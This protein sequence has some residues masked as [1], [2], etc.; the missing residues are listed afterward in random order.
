MIALDSDVYTLYLQGNESIMSKMDQ[1]H[2]VLITLPI[3]VVE[4][5]IRG[6]FNT[7]RQ[8]QTESKRERLPVAYERLAFTI[9]SC[10]NFPLLAYTADAEVLCQKWKKHKIRVPTQ[11][12]RIAA[13]CVSQGFKL[14]TNNTRDFSLIP[15]LA[16][17]TWN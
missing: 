9:K 5:V 1:R 8:C 4:E 2:H 11:D 7:I 6:R 3:V 17:E 14:A 15:E 10:S 16:L 12:M 13:I